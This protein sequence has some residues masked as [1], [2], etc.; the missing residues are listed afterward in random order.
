MAGGNKKNKRGSIPSQSSAMSVSPKKE[1]IERTADNDYGVLSDPDEQTAS[2]ISPTHDT[3]TP[4]PTNHETETSIQKSSPS[5]SPSV[6]TTL[7]SFP[8][9]SPTSNGLECIDNQDEQLPSSHSSQQSSPQMSP[10]SPSQPLSTQPPISQSPTSNKSLDTLKLKLTRDKNFSRKITLHTFFSYIILAM[11]IQRSCSASIAHL[12][13][14][15]VQ[16]L[17]EYMIENHSSSNPVRIYLHTLNDTG[18]VKNIIESIIDFNKDNKNSSVESLYTL[19]ENEL[20]MFIL[21]SANSSSPSS[22]ATATATAT[23]VNDVKVDD[24][25]EK[26]ENLPQTPQK[27]GFFKRMRCCLFSGCCG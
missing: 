4:L 26:S 6:P 19:E 12:S 16:D 1:L 2:T 3:T 8:H 7:L 10:L 27:C 22:T 15:S 11:E 25:T 14:K 24:T 5:L 17:V 13:V 20:E 23:A 18:V 9:H 21:Q